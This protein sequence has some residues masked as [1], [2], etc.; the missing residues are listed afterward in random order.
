M[1]M[2]LVS[3]LV[4]ALF[5]SFVSCDCGD[6]DDG[7]LDDDGDD[8]IS[9]D[10]DLDDGADDADD[11][12][13]DDAADDSAD[14][15]ADDAD[16][17]DDDTDD[18]IVLFSEDFSEYATGEVMY[19]W[20]VVATGTS[21][22]EIYDS[23]ETGYDNCLKIFGDT[24]DGQYI[25]I[26]YTIPRFEQDYF[27]Q[28]DIK[29]EGV[30]YFILSADG[31]STWGASVAS[32]V[33]G[34]LYAHNGADWSEECGTLTLDDWNTVELLLHYP[35]GLYDVKVGGITVCTDM[36][37]QVGTDATYNAIVVGDTVFDGEGGYYYYDNI[38]AGPK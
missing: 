14:D 7:R 10:D 21:T 8:T 6:D 37:P 4:A 31:G 34:T 1:R 23:G 38:I 25:H 35:T 29:P 20:V 15:S 26:S 2:Y 5:G 19:P 17:D 13:A 24:A 16:D 36:D 11:D 33:D 32:G 28:L 30:G 22:A 18:D 12:S 9:T 27:V 3:I